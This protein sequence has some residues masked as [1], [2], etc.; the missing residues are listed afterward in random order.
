MDYPRAVDLYRKF[1]AEFPGTAKKESALIMIA[2]CSLLPETEGG[3]SVEAGKAALAQLE[4]E[5]P[6]SRF[7]EAEIGLHARLDYVEGRMDTA[8]HT[9]MSTHDMASLEI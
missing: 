6:H 4:K 1:L 3:R 8:L 9:Y 7:R 2:R 5:F